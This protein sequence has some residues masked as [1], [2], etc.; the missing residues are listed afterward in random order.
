M[1]K[2]LVET[3]PM[4]LLAEEHEALRQE[5]GE[6]TRA[7]DSYNFLRALLGR[8]TPAQLRDRVASLREDLLIHFRHEEEGFFS[9]IRKALHESGYDQV[10][11]HGFFDSE[12]RHDLVAHRILAER[13]Q[14]MISLLDEP[15][16][17]AGLR[18]KMRD[19]L[20]TIMRDVHHVFARH[21]AAEEEYIYP[22]GAEI[23][24]MT[25]L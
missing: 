7:V 2:T 25:Y 18:L 24:G 14:E 6:L 9:F 12:N 11:L 21:F 3:P 10:L 22:M 19:R 5:I 13:T 8:D 4:A 17:G 16:R 23:L 20:L 15:R 1:T